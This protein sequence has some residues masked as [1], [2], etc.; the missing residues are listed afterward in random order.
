L[1]LLDGE[2]KTALN[3]GSEEIVGE[4][5]GEKQDFSESECTLII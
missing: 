3:I 4:L 5:I 2:Y 1:Q